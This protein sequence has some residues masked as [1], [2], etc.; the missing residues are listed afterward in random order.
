MSA[1]TVRVI[2]THVWF[3]F[4]AGQPPNSV[5]GQISLTVLLFI[6]QVYKQNLPRALY[7]C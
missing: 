7:C 6:H 2:L 5:I 4:T 3:T 1:S